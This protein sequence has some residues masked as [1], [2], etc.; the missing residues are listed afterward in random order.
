MPTE[1]SRLASAEPNSPAEPNSAFRVWLKAAN[2]PNSALAFSDRHDH[3]LP[4]ARRVPTR[5]VV[6]VP[7]DDQRPIGNV[8]AQFRDNAAETGHVQRALAVGQQY[9]LRARVGCDQIPIG[10]RRELQRQPFGRHDLR[11]PLQCALAEALHR[12]WR[13]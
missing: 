10:V 12:C 4:N 5:H 7:I 1:L 2:Q 6:F 13:A 9:R 3:Q 11:Q 8:Q